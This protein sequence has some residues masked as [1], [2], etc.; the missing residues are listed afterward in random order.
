MVMRSLIVVGTILSLF[1]SRPYTVGFGNAQGEYYVLML[2]ACLGAMLLCGANDLVM[3]FVAFETL[4]I[5]CFALSGYTKFDKLSNEAA[6]KYV[7]IGAVSSACLLYGFSFLYGITGETNIVSISTFLT[8]YAVNPVLL[9]AFLFVLGGFGYKIA[10][11][12]FHAWAPD[13]YEGAPVPVAAFLSVVSKAAGFAIIIRFFGNVFSTLPQ[14]GMIVGGVAVVTMT[15][16]NIFAMTQSNLKRFLAYS[17]IAQAGY[18]LL[19]VVI[20]TSQGISSVVFYLITYLVTNFGMWAAV[21]IF[22]KSTGKDTV[23]DLKGIGFKKPMLAIGFVV[24]LLSLAGIPFTASFF[25]KFY[26]FQSVLFAGFQYM[27]LLIIALVNTLIAVYYYFRLIKSMFTVEEPEAATTV[28]I[29]SDLKNPL[30]HGVLYSMVIAIVVIGFFA[31]PI[32][33][34][35]KTGVAS[36]KLPRSS[37]QANNK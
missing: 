22:I 30:L 31:G 2:T 34:F 3:I 12:P 36:V 28:P 7:I 5:S 26:L 23:D 35:S 4:S 18:I 37:S 16:G 6:L 17:S 10:A 19:G 11:V 20:F 1:L 14:L 9:I 25:G 21:E 33:A 32:I 27:W 15:I 24:C 13:V 8:T 29:P